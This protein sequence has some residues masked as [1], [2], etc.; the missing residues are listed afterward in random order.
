MTYLWNNK[1]KLPYIRSSCKM[2]KTDAVCNEIN[3]TQFQTKTEPQSCKQASP[4]LS[5]IKYEA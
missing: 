1:Q 5:P 3:H 2:R 4:V